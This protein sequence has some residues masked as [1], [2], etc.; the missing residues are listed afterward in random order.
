LVQVARCQNCQ[1]LQRLLNSV[2]EKMNTY[3]MSSKGQDC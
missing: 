2:K 1:L 3:Q